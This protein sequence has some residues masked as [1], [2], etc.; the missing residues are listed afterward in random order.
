[1]LETGKELLSNFVTAPSIHYLYSKLQKFRNLTTVF[2]WIKFFL[3]DVFSYVYI[4]L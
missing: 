1:M 2:M 3:L 4:S